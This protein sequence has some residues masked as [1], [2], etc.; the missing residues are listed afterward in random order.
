MSKTKDL[1]IGL[2]LGGTKVLAAIISEKG[3]II[4]E[5]ESKT[6]TNQDVSKVIIKTINQLLV[7]SKVDVNRLLGIGVASAGVIDSSKKEILYAN[8]LNIENFPIGDI[9]LKEFLLPVKLC[10]DANAAAI[11]E[12]VWGVGRGKNN[13]VYVTVSTGVGAGIIIDG[14]LLKGAKDSAGEFG[15]TTIIHNGKP[16]ECG[17][18]GCLEKYASGT[19]I[20][21]LANDRLQS[22]EVSILSELLHSEKEVANNHI[23]FAAKEG[24]LFSIKLLNEIGNYLGIGVVNLIHLFN[25][26]VV[27]F[28]G[29]VMN[30]SDYILPSVK[31]YIKEHGIKQMTEDV[32]IEKTKLGKSAGIM[33]AS[34]L[35]FAGE[36][37][38]TSLTT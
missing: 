9:L 34:G 4:S 35:F 20:K 18:I 30:M 12:W 13:L 14:N 15:H 33:G 29:G 28:G 1:A 2:D 32:I 3:K 26:E 7:K 25:T 37:E 31:K 17:N 8:N 38:K 11:A 23:A 10:N 27:V 19:A 16:C 21:K 22:G 5:F 36:R 24:D 6:D